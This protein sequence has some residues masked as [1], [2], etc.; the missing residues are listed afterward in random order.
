MSLMPRWCADLGKDP[1][2]V[3]RDRVTQH[4]NLAAGRVHQAEQHADE[5]GLAAAVR[6]EQAVS[7]PLADVEADLADRLDVAEA[8]GQVLCRDHWS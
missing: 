6:A 1:A 8:L 3:L 2:H 4:G 5:R 7:V